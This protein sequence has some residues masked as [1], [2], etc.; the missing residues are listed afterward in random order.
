MSSSPTR[1]QWRRIYRQTIT[2][3]HKN[4]L[5][6]WK[7]PISTLIRAFIFPIILTLIFCFLKYVNASPSYQNQTGG[8]ANSPSQVKDLAEAINASPSRRLVFVRNGISNE[9]I[10]PIIDGITQQPGM[11]QLD[12]HTVDDPNDLFDL[13]K[14]SL[15]GYSDCFAAVIF[16]SYND[17]NV[18][19][20]IAFDNS[21]IEDYS[22]GDFATDDS[23]LANRILPV[24]WAVESHIGNFSS[25]PRPQEQTFSG[26]FGPHAY[27]PV[28]PPSAKGAFWLTIVAAYTAPIFILILIGVVYHLSTFVA[29]ERQSTIAELMA[30]QRVTAVPRILSTT[31]SFYL[32]YFPGFLVSS[33]LLTQILFTKTSDILLL[34][35]TLLAGGSLINT[36]H[37]VAS[38]FGKAQLAGLYTS[39]LAFALAL[40]ALAASLTIT[41]PQAQ[42]ISLSVIFPPYTWATLMRDAAATEYNLKAFSLFSAKMNETFYEGDS[43]PVEKLVNIQYLNGYLYI[44]FFV[45]QIIVYGGATYAVEQR[46][47]GVTRKFDRI[48]ASSDIALRCTNLSKT[49]HAK[50]PWYWPFK[51]KGKTVVAVDNL[52]LEVKKGSVTFLLGP[53]GGGKTTTLKCV[54]GITGM[55][56]GSH[57]ELN[58]AG[59]VFGIC[60]Q[61]NVRAIPSI[62]PELIADSGQQVFWDS[63]T[64]QEHIMIWRKLKTAAFEDLTVDDDDV[65]VECDLL[66]K[67]KAPANTLSGG[68]M[69]KLQLAIAFVGGSKVCCI[70]EASS[71][72]VSP[73][74]CPVGE[75]F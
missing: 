71:G 16:V 57:L 73:L 55:D 33:I 36:T 70:D 47:W 34:F 64:V 10:N 63:L 1:P 65:L 14:Q 2:L 32:I 44:V 22:Y 31:L 75:N 45:V 6:F 4:L 13:C 21:I 46:L 51:T 15:Q 12:T 20:S 60:P 59:L 68:Q 39:V 40:V 26:N 37:F 53:N 62:F 18:E 19:Y 43:S 69:R 41:D 8:I 9:T 74:Y 28:E 7:A 5:I 25:L 17:T 11:L 42:I 38:F 35:L 48:D 56:Q 27:T 72:L 3:I 67:V 61:T 52:D 54:A 49:Y 58:E 29:T 50:R 66:E 23:L 30:A 24:Q